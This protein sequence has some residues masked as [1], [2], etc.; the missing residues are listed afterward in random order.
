M[1]ILNASWHSY[2]TEFQGTF[3][4]FLGNR[5]LETRLSNFTGESQIIMR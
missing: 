5:V 3:S 1:H 2:V 4:E